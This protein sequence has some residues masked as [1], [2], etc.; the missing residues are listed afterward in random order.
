VGS[1]ICSAKSASKPNPT[2]CYT[3]CQLEGWGKTTTFSDP[4]RDGNLC[5]YVVE[6]Q[7]IPEGLATDLMAHSLGGIFYQE[8]VEITALLTRAAPFYSLTSGRDLLSKGT[9]VEIFPQSVG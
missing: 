6:V 8:A 1:W 7:V 4:F 9:D 3:F 2:G 5:A